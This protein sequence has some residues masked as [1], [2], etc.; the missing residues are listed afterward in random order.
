MEQ[1]MSRASN[2]ESPRIHFPRRAK[3]LLLLAV[4]VLAAVGAYAWLEPTPSI[5][6][7]TITRGD[8]RATVNA[9]AQVR[10]VRSARLSF[11]MSGQ[12]ARV[13]VKEGD[14]VKAGDVLAELQSDDYDR[15]VKQAELALASHQLDLERAQAAPRAEDLEIAQANL[16]KAALALAA[17]ED[18]AKKNPGTASDA[19][20]EVAQA[21]YDIARANF[22]RLTRGPSDLDLQTLK[23][24]ITSA[25]LD[26]DAARQALAQTQIRA[27]YDGIV[28]EV[29]AQPGELIGGFNPVVGLADLTQLELLAEIDEID[30]GAVT[31]GQAVEIHLDAFPGETLSGKLTQ[32]FPAASNVRGALIYQAR[33]QF[34]KG[35]LAVRPGMGATIKIATV[36]KKNVL[37]VPSRAIRDAG[38]QKIVSEYV[39]GAVENVVVE[40]GLSD[41]NQTEIV[42]GLEPG[43]KVVI[44]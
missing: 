1:K 22:D 27:P 13:L 16:K 15:R 12:L 36:E 41:G 20:Q 24:A 31:P 33:I 42:S 30:V 19:A 28:T 25:Q 32:L 39:N 17:A 38:T 14:T 9:N 3:F 4:V 44:E 34:D 6:T 10:A 5:S 2:P 37:L 23:N 40:T 35:E 11:P 43:A 8:I 26:L 21:D 18:N 7:Y 29:D